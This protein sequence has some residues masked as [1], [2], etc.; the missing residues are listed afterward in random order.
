MIEKGQ[1]L[2]LTGRLQA[3]QWGAIYGASILSS[4]L[5]GYLCAQ[6]LEQSAFLICG[7]MMLVTLGLAVF[8]V[9][10]RRARVSADEFRQT[11]TALRTAA[12]SRTIVAVGIFMFFW[13][14]N[15]F[16]TSVLYLHMTRHM[17]FSEQFYGDNVALGAAAS[18][19]GSLAYG[20]Y[21]RRFGMRTLI[22]FSILLGVIS[23]LAYWG[24]RDA[25]SARA[26]ALV[27]GFALATGTVIQL[28]LAAQV[29]PVRAAGTL[30]ALLMSLSNL[31][32]AVATWFGGW[33]YE[34]TLARW[35][36]SLAFDLLVG[37]GG[38][39]TAVCWLIVP[40]L[41]PP[42][43]QSVASRAS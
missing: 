17:Q 6:S 14:F 16:L 1:P 2:G 24:L 11:H 23:M 41:N 9:K 38:L 4:S 35:G 12:G 21:C 32:T 29:C 34:A 33:C 13:N 27:S 40:Y 36:N 5:G 10:D 15:P 3:A 18:M 30:F 22:H 37:I 25:M 28:D 43:S 8:A 31:G 19:I 20:W 39:F 7:L 42:S 26:V